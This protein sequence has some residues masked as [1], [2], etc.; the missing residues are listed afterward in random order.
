MTA[1]D[2]LGT[3]RTVLKIIGLCIAVVAVAKLFGV[4]IPI[5]ASIIELAAVAL[6]C[7]HA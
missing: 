2:A 7:A 4:Q 1:N 3:V 5:R 6:A